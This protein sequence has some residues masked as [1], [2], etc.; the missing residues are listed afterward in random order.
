MSATKFV[1]LDDR[2]E[3]LAR[4]RG[5]YPKMNPPPHPN[6]ERIRERFASFADGFRAGWRS[7]K[8]KPN[9]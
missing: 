3:N 6:N 7:A 8:R 9:E 5:I 4:H 2:I 1:S